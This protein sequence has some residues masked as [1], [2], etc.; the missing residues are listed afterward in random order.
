VLVLHPPCEQPQGELTLDLTGALEAAHSRGVVHRDLNPSNV[1]LGP[2][3][4]KVIEAHVLR[5][6]NKRGPS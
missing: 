1:L 6:G 5:S 4:T 2:Q 3:G